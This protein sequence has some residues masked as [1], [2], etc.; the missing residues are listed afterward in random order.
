[1]MEEHDNG[2]QHQHQ[3]STTNS[4]TN[5]TPQALHVMMNVDDRDVPLLETTTTPRSPGSERTSTTSSAPCSW[6]TTWLVKSAWPGM[7]L[8]GESYLLFSIGTLQPLWK[9]IFPD[10][11]KYT[12]CT[13]RV[14]NSLTYSVVLGVICGM[15]SVGYL[16]NTMGRRRT[17]IWTAAFM[18][19]G[20]FGMVACTFWFVDNPNL[21]YKS[22]SILLFLFG[23]GVGG[24]YP[25]SASCASEKSMIALQ[26][27]RAM[28]D[29]EQLDRIEQNKS[30]DLDSGTAL[31]LPAKPQTRGR[32]IQLVFCMQGLGIW[33]NSLVLVVLL[34]M[35]GQTNYGEYNTDTLLSI[36]RVTYAIGAVILLFVLISRILYL[37]ESQVWLDDK[38]RRGLLERSVTHVPDNSTSPDHRMMSPPGGMLPPSIGISSSTVSS[39]SCPSVALDPKD[40]RMLRRQVS[41]CDPQ[42]DVQSSPYHLLL[43]NYGVRLF[44]ASMSW[45]L[46]DIAFYG[47]KLFQST[48]LMALTGYNTTLVQFQTAALLNA[49]VALL[50]Y[51][52]AAFLV[53][54]PL[55][56]RLRMQQV[57]FLITGTLFLTCG[58]SFH[59]LSSNW[60]ITMY[61]AS[62]FFG[63]LGPNAT[64][65]LIPAEIFPTEM[66]TLC[67]GICAASGKLGAL[68]AAIL[69]HHV[70]DVEMFL[71]SGYA[72]FAA[73]AIT[74]W[75]LPETT[76]LDLYEL[77]RKW[78]MTLDGRKRE[79]QGDANHPNYLSFY[80][81]K[82]RG[83]PW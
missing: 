3:H 8:F 16:A 18:T 70:S 22:M 71:I 38:R 74:F 82:K 64:T 55:V 80:E 59:Q 23:L 69:F 5:A 76:G 26:Q 75:T 7:G 83:I 42:T 60:L 45:M 40:E 12:S 63:Q 27:R 66:R 9:K 10:C 36:W 24:E 19:S 37:Q 31:T 33:F 11:F 30:K 20:A 52:G 56:G 43:R 14:L 79:Y 29:L 41:H 47:N 25:L 48:F 62:S 51:F 21:L 1:M 81:R 39:L 58:F 4:Y 13:P 17:S 78:R 15:L 61:L 73:C 65:F 32:Q 57:G 50:G 28:D 67:H 49:T 72:S 54:H 34:V 2:H 53:D 6:L 77:D 46:W 35:T 44:G 68:L